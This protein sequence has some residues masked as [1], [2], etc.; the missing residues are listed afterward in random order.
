MRPLSLTLV[1]FGPFAGRTELDFAR[2]GTRGLYLITGVT[3][4]GKTTLFD[5]LTF[6]LYG[7]PSGR[8]RRP[9]MLAS[10][11]AAPGE[12]PLARLAFEHRGQ[13]YTVER[14]LPYERPRQRGTGTVQVPGGA[15]FLYP[16]GRAPLT[17]PAEVTQTVTGLLGVDRDQFCQIAMIAQGAFQE[18]LLADT[19]AR[20]AIFR[21]IFKTGPYQDFQNRVK[22]DALALEDACRQAERD[23]Q[24]LTDGIRADTDDPLAPELARLHAAVPSAADVQSL[25]MR[26]LAQDEH[27]L[28]ALRTALEQDD[29]LLEAADAALG[30]AVQLDALRADAAEAEGWLAAQTPVLDTLQAALATEQAR[31]PRLEQL[32]EAIPVARADLAR[33]AALEALVARQ[34]ALQAAAAQAEANAAQLANDTASL[35]MR[36]TATRAELDALSGAAAAVERLAAEERRAAERIAALES[37]QTQ[38]E[39][40]AHAE[41]ALA[42]AQTRYLRAADE[43]ETARRALDAALRLFLDGQAGVLARTL[44]P[45]QP[46]PVCGAAEHPA[47][48]ALQAHVPTEAALDAQRASADA[49]AKTAVDR[50][51]EAARRRGE[52]EQARVALLAAAEPL[53]GATEPEA[54]PALL[55]AALAEARA[56]HTAAVQALAQA[57][58]QAQRAERVREGLPRAEAKLTKQEADG[59]AAAQEA[60]QART[61]AAALQTRIAE[62]QAQLPAANR[63]EAEAR[64]QAL[65]DERTALT[66]ALETAQTAYST[67]RE[68][69]ALRRAKLETLHAQLAGAPQSDTAAQRTRREGLAAARAERLARQ[70]ALAARRQQ[71]AAT[72]DSLRTLAAQSEAQLRQRAWLSTLSQTVNGTLPGKEKI[73]LETYV[74]TTVLDHILARANTRLMRMSNGQFELRRRAAAGDLRQRSGLELNVLDHYAGAERDVRSLSGGE[75]FKASLALALGMSDEVQASAGGVQ[76]DTLFIDEGFGSLD[77]DSLSTAVDVLASL[78]EGN[79]LVGIISHVQQLKERIDRQIVVTR[80]RVGSHVEIRV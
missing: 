58:E 78:G 79:R 62:E 44:A 46:C 76:L 53:L 66:R 39:N 26:L 22:A 32:A 31:A 61:E 47:P 2:L 77:D 70:Q 8:N 59:L 57:Q 64:L 68:G 49:L 41:V 71:N 24:R 10:Q 33:L 13:T 1:A 72:L 50:S 36:L 4:A 19:A 52:A 69:I 75:Q 48:A 73:T 23:L 29:H 40:V 5:A 3:G 21:E 14:T 55:P 30:R 42:A 28:D 54:L 65:Q 9:E 18:L 16:D 63:A 6:A 67:T 17:R 74:Q 15:T 37:L 51:A 80:T 20:S 35:R 45:G 34:A 7:E 56:A 38:R 12:A 11:Y 43:S 60:A 25:L 27:A